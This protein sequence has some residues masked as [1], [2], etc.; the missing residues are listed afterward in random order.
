MS[1]QH[2]HEVAAWPS[3]VQHRIDNTLRCLPGYI[4][5][6]GRH[7]FDDRIQGRKILAYALSQNINPDSDFAIEWA[8][9]WHYSGGMAALDR[10]NLCYS[11]EGL[12]A[13]HPFDTGHLPILCGFARW[14]AC[15][16]NATT[17]GSIYDEIAATNLS[18]Y[19]FRSPNG[20]TSDSEVSLRLCYDWFS[21]KEI[22]VL[23]P[24]IIIC[25]GDQ[26]AKVLTTALRTTRIKVLPV[27]FPST[28][29]INIRYRKLNPTGPQIDEL[30]SMF[31]GADLDR[32][33]K[34][35]NRRLGDILEQD[36]SFFWPV[37]ERMRARMN[38]AF[39]A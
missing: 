17:E 22:S 36:S 5:F 21:T 20:K 33:L 38:E 30:R 37:F 3:V 35:K 19:S 14:L 26:V 11:Q 1:L 29:V 23:K 25:A 16:T 8:K 9:D 4:P 24:D 6:I 2:E 31:S 39:I 18:K 27:P 32:K 13:M 34:S 12:V 28:R 7:Y 15:P 10:Q